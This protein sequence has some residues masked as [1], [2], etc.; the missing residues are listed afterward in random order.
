MEEWE[1]RVRSAAQWGGAS[2]P[3]SLPGPEVSCG[4]CFVGPTKGPLLLMV[5]LSSSRF[6][7]EH[8][9]GFVKGRISGR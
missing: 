7:I 2:P 4:V 8:L 5:A 6:M 3:G 9:C 1:V